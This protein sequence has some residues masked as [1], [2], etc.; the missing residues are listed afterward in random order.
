MPLRITPN[1]EDYSCE[2]EFGREAIK[3]GEEEDEVLRAPCLRECEAA[4]PA[5]AAAGG[6]RDGESAGRCPKLEG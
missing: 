3:E 4:A 2:F 6:G 5:A 1:F